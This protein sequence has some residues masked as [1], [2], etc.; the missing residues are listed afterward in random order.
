MNVPL[1]GSTSRV[2]FYLLLGLMA[3]FSVALLVFF[4]KRRWI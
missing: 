1:P 2:S 4:R 3:G